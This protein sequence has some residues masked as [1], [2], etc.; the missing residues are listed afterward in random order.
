M[1]MK[2]VGEP[3][4]DRTPGQLEMGIGCREGPR[5]TS[6]T[7]HGIL[8]ADGFL[9][10]NRTLGSMVGFRTFRRRKVWL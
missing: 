5:W 8:R 6:F 9:D 7:N 10:G 3:N 1:R 4:K 2:V